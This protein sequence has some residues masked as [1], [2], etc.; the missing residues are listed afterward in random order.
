MNYNIFDNDKVRMS[1]EFDY[2]FYKKWGACTLKVVLKV[3][4]FGG[5]NVFYLDDEIINDFLK[6]DCGDAFLNGS[7]IKLIDLESQ[8]VIEFIADKKNSE[9]IRVVG[10]L[11]NDVDSLAFYFD[12]LANKKLFESF[13]KCVK[14]IKEKYC[15]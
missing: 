4:G 9:N 12:F 10:Q 5:E 14:E 2:G 3:N 15:A 6:L 13:Y 1:A 7:S 11:G 8:S